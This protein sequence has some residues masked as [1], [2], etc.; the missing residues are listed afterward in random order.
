MGCLCMGRTPVCF[1]DELYISVLAAMIQSFA[2][3]QRCTFILFISKRKKTWSYV[4]QVRT[5]P[6]AVR[7]ALPRP[8]VCTLAFIAL[9]SF[10]C[11]LVPPGCG[12][13]LC[14]GMA[15]PRLCAQRLRRLEM[16]G[17]RTLM[18]RRV[19]MRWRLCWTRCALIRARCFF[20]P[21]WTRRWRQGGCPC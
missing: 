11:A 5:A 20:L 3:S 12:L 4:Q 14:F 15:L 1:I 10:P 21:S 8:R 13:G 16:R 7:R 18:T 2:N 19:P 9:C 17:R 6:T